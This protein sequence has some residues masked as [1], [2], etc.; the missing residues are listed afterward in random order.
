MGDYARQRLA[1]KR[2][3]RF[4]RGVDFELVVAGAKDGTMT[5]RGRSVARYTLRT[6]LYEIAIIFAQSA[7]FKTLAGRCS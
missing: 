7:L 3:F 6:I 1:A 5:F 2:L 4:W